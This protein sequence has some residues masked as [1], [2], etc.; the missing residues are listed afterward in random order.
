MT[1]ISTINITYQATTD[2]PLSAVLQAARRLL[3]ECAE[4][5]CVA[6][7]RTGPALDIHATVTKV[8]DSNFSYHIV[9]HFDAMMHSPAKLI[10]SE[11]KTE[12][13]GG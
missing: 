5:E 13:S 1:N 9:E 8:Q 10:T 4:L 2:V 6:I 3:M 11:Q 12:E 7:T